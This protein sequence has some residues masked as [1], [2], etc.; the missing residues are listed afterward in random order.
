M[1]Y[2]CASNYDRSQPMG[3][4]TANVIEMLRRGAEILE[5]HGLVMVLNH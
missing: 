1:D 3:Y 2:R 5:P 4:Q